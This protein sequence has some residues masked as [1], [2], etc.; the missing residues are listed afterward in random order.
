MNTKLWISAFGISL[1][2]L[3]VSAVSLACAQPQA[4]PLGKP[5][6]QAPDFKPSP[7]PPQP[8][9]K[10]LVC[11][12][13]KEAKFTKDKPELGDKSPESA[14]LREDPKTHAVDVIV[15]L[16][17]GCTLPAHWHS[18]NVT[19][20][21]IKGVY[22]MSGDNPTAAPG[23]V[24]MGPGS[25]N[26]T[27]AGLIHSGRVKGNEP[28][29][30]FETF[31]RARDVKLID[32]DGP[33]P[34]GVGEGMTGPRPEMV[35]IKA[36]DVKWRPFGDGVLAE[37]AVLHEDPGTHAAQIMLRAAGSLYVPRHWHP[38]GESL[39]VL[40]GSFSTPCRGAKVNLDAGSYA[41][42]PPKIVQNGWVGNDGVML[43]ICTDGAG[44][45][46]KTNWVENPTTPA[47][48]QEKKE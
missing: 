2:A 5:R 36:A 6:P 10:L 12:P 29:L 45:S 41:Y 32:V 37:V 40:S 18:A 19:H 22:E 26:F 16:P 44:G 21:I 47:D 46:W 15:K 38:A 14:V 31:D 3:S 20:T 33:P 7:I 25:F 17:P 8:D 42:F 34:K 48:P 1:C 24:E 27:P 9:A 35:Y 4:Q 28:V 11:T 23:G 39:A 30:M 43:L 13:F